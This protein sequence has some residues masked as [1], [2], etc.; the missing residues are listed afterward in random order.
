LAKPE[1]PSVHN[2]RAKDG[3]TRNRIR[4][5]VFL[6]GCTATPFGDVVGE[7]SFERSAVTVVDT[8]V[9][10]SF[11]DGIRVRGSADVVGVEVECAGTLFA[12][13]RDWEW[14]EK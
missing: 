4:T 1:Y 8:V 5:Y 2:S 9:E 11:E 14:F 10:K 7:D 13:K 6:S 12:R 3:I